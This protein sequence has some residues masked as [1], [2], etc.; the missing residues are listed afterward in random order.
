M[1]RVFSI[2]N[3]SI[4]LEDLGENIEEQLSGNKGGK[5]GGRGPSRG[6]TNA[7]VAKSNVQNAENSRRKEA[8]EEVI[9]SLDHFPKSDNPEIN[10]KNID[11]Y[12][13]WLLKSFEFDEPYIKT[14]DLDYSQFKAGGPGGQ[15]FNKVSNAVLYKH[16]PTGIF[17]NAKESRNTIENRNEASTILYEK[18][19][20]LIKD[21]KVVLGGIEKQNQEEAVKTFIQ[22]SQEK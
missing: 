21:W 16:L 2:S 19:Q 9:K 4:D 15:N 20:D 10:Q 1:P 3:S 6:K 17:A 5:R 13:D 8:E 12:A 11:K 18:L 7:A 14:E 22:K